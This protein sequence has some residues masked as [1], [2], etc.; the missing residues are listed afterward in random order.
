MK[1]H[2]RLITHDISEERYYINI[3]APDK[4]DSSVGI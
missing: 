4:S 1:N 3:N 2:Y